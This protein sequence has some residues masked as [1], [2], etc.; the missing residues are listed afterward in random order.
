MPSLQTDAYV[1]MTPRG[2]FVVRPASVEEL[3]QIL[4]WAAAEGWNPGRHDAACFHCADP[5]GFF[6]GELNGEPVAAISAVRYGQAF[7]FIGCFLVRPE[8]RHARLGWHLTEVC[9]EHLGDRPTGL[10]GV[11]P[12]QR[13]YA[14]LG[15]QVAHRSFRFQG[16]AEGTQ[17]PKVVGLTRIPFEDVLLYDRRHFPAA[18]PEFLRAW[19]HQPEALALGMMR[20]SR[21]AGYG[22]L[23]RCQ[24]GY[25]IG[26]LFADDAA[27][28]EK[29]FQSL[30]ASVAGQPIFLDVPEPNRAA[31][32]LAESH[33][34]Q[35]VFE[36]A[37]MYS[38]APP[39]IALDQVY[40]I[41]S[42]ELG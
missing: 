30:G 41:T 3:E 34:M 1:T 11:V 35:V 32:A 13:T 17:H 36:T 9:R 27:I 19:I 12:M 25:K 37:R 15:F 10:D 28:A 16:V 24:T 29:L 5:Q 23:R 22:V 21:L 39:K 14:R 4:S 33:R 38:A 6:L 40:G 2:E 20:D 31:L 8:Y 42:F 7:A 18:R 26:P